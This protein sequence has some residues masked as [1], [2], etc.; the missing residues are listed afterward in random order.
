MGASALVALSLAGAANAADDPTAGAY[1]NI[2]RVTNAKGETPEFWINKVG[3][4][5]AE[6]KRNAGDKRQQT[7][8]DCKPVTIEN[9]AGEQAACLTRRL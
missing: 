2:V 5:K 8:A 7:D 4:N 1:G 3:A 9:K 6:E